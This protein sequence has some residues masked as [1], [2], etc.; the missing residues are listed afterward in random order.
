MMN[1]TLD[2]LVREYIDSLRSLDYSPSTIRT[3]DRTCRRLLAQTGNIQLRN[4]DVKHVDRYFAIRMGQGVSAPTLNIELQNLRG[5]FR[6][7][8]ARRYMG[9]TPDPTAH[10]R[11]MRVQPKARRRIPAGEFTRLLDACEHPRDRMVVALGVYLMLRQSEIV[12]LRVGDVNLA[13]GEVT[14]H[15]IKTAKLDVMPISLELDSELRRWLTWYTDT[16][17]G[18]RDDYLLVPAK[19]R[20]VVMPDGS[21]FNLM[22]SPLHPY[23]MIGHPQDIVRRAMAACGYDLNDADGVTLRDGVH[24]LRRSAARAKFD[25]LVDSGYDGALRVVQSMCHHASQKQTEIYIGVEL[26]QKRRDDM[27]RGKRMYNIPQDN[28]TELRSVK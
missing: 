4:I 18:L 25:E 7:A 12:R 21:G 2:T 17:G 24:T 27:I 19:A 8:M 10:R 15:I 26:D 1:P 13:T 5:L 23:K 9:Q 11:R 20:P 3:A 16:M 14:A 22:D 6:Y 28:V